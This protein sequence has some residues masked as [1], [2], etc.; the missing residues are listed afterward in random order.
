MHEGRDGDA[1][2]RYGHALAAASQRIG[3]SYVWAAPALRVDRLPAGALAASP[4]E[5]IV[6]RFEL[7]QNSDAIEKPVEVSAVLGGEDVPPVMLSQMM[8]ELQRM[9]P[10]SRRLRRSDGLTAQAYLFS[11]STVTGLPIYGRRSC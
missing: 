6:Q 2:A 4:V 9:S 3:V 11:V 8:D 1:V 7:L 10:A 5:H